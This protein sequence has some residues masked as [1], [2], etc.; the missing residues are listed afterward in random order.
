MLCTIYATS[1]PSLGP[2]VASMGRTEVFTDPNDARFSYIITYGGE[3][4]N[5]AY[6][7]ELW[8]LQVAPTYAFTQ[9]NVENAIP[10]SK[11]SVVIWDSV[12]NQVLLMCGLSQQGELLNAS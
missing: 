5:S 11:Q 12:N 6:S 7:N 1:L 2:A 3:Y 4:A 9:L 10:P 8:R